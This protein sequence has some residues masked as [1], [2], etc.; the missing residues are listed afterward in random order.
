MGVYWRFREVPQMS[1]RATTVFLAILLCGIAGA[2]AAATRNHS[3]GG[4]HRIHPRIG[5]FIAAPLLLPRYAAAPLYDYYFTNPPLVM[6][7]PAYIQQGGLPSG[8]PGQGYWYYCADPQGYYPYVEQCPG[9]WQ[10]VS[11][12][13][14]AAQ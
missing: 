4:P 11:P 8:E 7:P 12:V 14:P 3:H 10:Q 13:P 9:G 1:A 2:A 6:A 5:A